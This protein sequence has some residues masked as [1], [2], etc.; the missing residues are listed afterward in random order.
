M[1]SRRQVCPGCSCLCDG[2]TIEND[3]KI[4]VEAANCSVGSAWFANRSQPIESS[5]SRIAEVRTLLESASA[6]LITGIENL[7]TETQQAAV[8]VADRFSTYIDSGLSNVGRG[9]MASFQRYGKVTA[10]LGEVASRSDLVVLWFCDPVTTH[11]RFIERF[12]RNSSGPKKRLIVIDETKTKTAEIADEFICV[13]AGNALSFIQQLRMSINADSEKDLAAELMDAKYGSVFVGNPKNVDSKFDVITDQWFQLVR[14]LNDHTRFVMNSLRGDR[15]GIGANNV[16]TSLCG[17]PNAIRFTE[18]GPT[19]NGL[20]FSTASLIQRRDCDL[21]IA[22][23]IGNNDPFENCLDAKSIAW[24]KKIPVVVLSD[25]PA[26]K[27]Q[28]ATVHI[29]TGTP[30]WTAVGDYVRMDNVPVPMS[31]LAG[32][33]VR[34]VLDLF[35]GLLSR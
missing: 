15:N 25:L 19:Y 32:T 18:N 34:I 21:L 3:S 1:S 12:V 17:F 23:D 27:Y 6:P 35:N 5:T 2:L 16:L 26:N 28:T 14:S 20:E 30:G 29:G 4:P 10:T 22:C 24:L 7:T 8:R 33:E 11:P 13:Q 31:A 9:S